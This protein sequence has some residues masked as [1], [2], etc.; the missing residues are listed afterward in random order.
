MK[1]DELTGVLLDHWVAIA[2]QKNGGEWYMESDGVTWVRKGDS[3]VF[4]PSKLWQ[5]GGPIIEREI[6]LLTRHGPTNWNALAN[7]SAPGR[8]ST[9][10]IAAMRAYVASK[11]GDSVPDGVTA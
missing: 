5:C 4:R 3:T 1:T 9:P 11:F 7:G 2:E 8:G 6:G 10:L